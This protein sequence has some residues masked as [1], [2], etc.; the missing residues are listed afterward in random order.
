[1]RRYPLAGRG[2]RIISGILLMPLAVA[3]VTAGPATTTVA[4]APVEV[5][6][7]TAPGEAT[8]FAP[9]ET[10]IRVAGP[11]S[12]TFRNASSLTHNLTFTSGWTAATRTI[13]EPGTSDTL[14]LAPLAPGEYRFVCTIHEGMSGTLVVSGN[15]PG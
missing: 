4:P 8:A 10:V 12:L 6:V 2:A 3:C 1:V 14:V 7:T 13:V 5:A 9:A 15:T 11:I